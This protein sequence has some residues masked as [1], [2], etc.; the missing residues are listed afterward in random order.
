MFNIEISF[1][2]TEGASFLLF[3]YANIG[4]SQSFFCEEK[5]FFG[6]PGDH[7]D[8]IQWLFFKTATGHHAHVTISSSAYDLT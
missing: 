2:L 1:A 6:W 3:E 8:V 4:R 7:N 5:N